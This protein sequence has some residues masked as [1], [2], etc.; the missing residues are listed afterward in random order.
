VHNIEAIKQL[1]AKIIQIAGF[2]FTED[3]AGSKKKEEKRK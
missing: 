1:F 3:N 2:K